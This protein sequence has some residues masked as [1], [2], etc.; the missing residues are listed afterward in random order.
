MPKRKILLVGE[1]WV[2]DATHIKGFDHFSTATFHL[3]AEPLVAALAGSQFELRYMPAHEAQRDFPLRLDGLNA[4]D[5][6]ILSDIGSNTLLLHPDTW[7]HSRRTPNRLKLIRDYVGRGGGLMMIGGYFSFQGIN[8]GARYHGTPIEEA[9]PVDILPYDDRV[10]VPEGFVPVIKES[11]HPILQG[12][13]GRWPALLGFNEVKAK[14]GA[15]VLATVS[16]GYGSKPLLVLYCF[17]RDKRN[18]FVEFFRCFMGAIGNRNRCY[19]F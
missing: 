4:Y 15:V 5:A 10:E 3:G 11:R 9:L 18:S 2:S 16:K 7:I 17:S 12:F 1:S 6:I 14:P 19:S 13:R 8:G